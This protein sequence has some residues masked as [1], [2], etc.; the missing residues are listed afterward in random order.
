MSYPKHLTATLSPEDER[1]VLQ[2]V[3]SGGYKYNQYGECCLSEE[4]DDGVDYSHYCTLEE[5]ETTTKLMKQLRTE[6]TQTQPQPAPKQT[7]LQP[8]YSPHHQN[9][10]T[11][12][13]HNTPEQNTQYS[14]PYAPSPINKRPY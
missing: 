1:K 14:P 7:P 5:I 2:I 11:Y 4:D 10:K 9:P 8:P 3:E 12:Q 13:H 6:T